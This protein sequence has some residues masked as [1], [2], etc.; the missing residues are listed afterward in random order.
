MKI[1]K[2]ELNKETVLRLTENEA[3]QA[4]GGEA[5]YGSVLTVNQDS[6]CNTRC[7]HYFCVC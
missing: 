1:K 7:N 2:F 6:G 5:Q 4:N 3:A